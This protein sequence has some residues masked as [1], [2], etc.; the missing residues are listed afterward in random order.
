[1]VNEKQRVVGV[2]LVAVILSHKQITKS[3][4]IIS[5]VA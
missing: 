4:G 3:R 2:T 1:M 5:H